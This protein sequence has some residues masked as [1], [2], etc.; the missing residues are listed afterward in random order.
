MLNAIL[1]MIIL[2]LL[3]IVTNQLRTLQS[4][5]SAFHELLR[6]LKGDDEEC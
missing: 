3:L 6:L 1:L 5:A 4:Y 2:V